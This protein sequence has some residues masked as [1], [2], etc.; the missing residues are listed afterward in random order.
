MEQT[1]MKKN[2][3]MAICSSGTIAFM[4]DFSTTCKPV[5][6]DAIMLS[7]ISNRIHSART[8]RHASHQR[9]SACASLLTSS[10]KRCPP[11]QISSTCGGNKHP[12]ISRL[13]LQLLQTIILV[14][15]FLNVKHLAG[16]WWCLLRHLLLP[17]TLSFFKICLHPLSLRLL[18]STR[19]RF[20]S[21]VSNEDWMLVVA[22]YVRL[23]DRA[24]FLWAFIDYKEFS[25]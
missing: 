19:P 13:A 25:G 23:L 10:L 11:M 9:H 1:M 24:S 15:L 18:I 4:I 5:A 14:L 22:R 12:A 3:R 7:S 16:D 2:S 20:Q 21:W 17:S 6:R 8:D